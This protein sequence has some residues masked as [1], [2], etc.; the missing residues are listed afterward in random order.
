MRMASTRARVA[1]RVAAYAASQ[2]GAITAD[3]LAAT[4]PIQGPAGSRVDGGLTVW[5][6]G[7]RTGAGAFAAALMGN[8]ARQRNLQTATGTT[9]ASFGVSALPH[10]LG[11]TG[12]AAVD[13]SGQAASCA[14]TLNGPFGSG[15]TA[16]GTGVL[17]AA[18]PSGQG[19]LA[20]AFL[21]PVIAASGG[22][23]ALG[24]CRCGRTQRTPRP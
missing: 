3:E 6:P 10:D 16:T 23:V 20:S 22:D 13:A 7:G 12:F 15:H 2:G 24:G 11:S 14:L 5:L 8:L 1:A 4:A 21:T 17:L 18:T 19:G 9:L